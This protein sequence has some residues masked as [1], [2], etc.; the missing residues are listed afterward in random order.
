[1]SGHGG[2]PKGPLV[3]LVQAAVLAALVGLLFVTSRYFPAIHGRGATVA[4]I[5]FLLLAGTLTSQLVEPIKLPHLTGYLVAGAVAGPY[6]LNLVEHDAVED[7]AFINSLALA[8]IALAGGAELRLEVLRKSLRSL[9]WAMTV[10]CVLGVAAMTLV[11]FVARPLIPFARGMSAQMLLGVALLW[12]CISVSRSPSALLGILAQTRAQGP[13]ATFSVA[14]VM[15]SDV[16]VAVLF[17]AGMVIARPLIEPSATLSLQEFRELG[18]EILGSVAIGTTLGLALAAYMRLIG[19]QLILVLLAMGFGAW[20]VIRY[21][22]FDSLLTFLTAGFVVQNLSDQGEKFLH[23]I[24]RTGGVVY[25]LFFATAGAHLN[26]PLLAELWPAALLLGV[27]RAI[28]TVASARLAARF[29]GDPPMV[30]RWGWSSLISQAGLTLGLVV[31]VERTFPSFGTSFRALGIAVVALNEMVGP[32]F[33]KLGLDRA[34]ES[35]TEPA[36]TRAALTSKPPLGEL[37]RASLTPATGEAP[38][39]RGLGPSDG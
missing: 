7:M 23:A 14:F 4:S 35:S 8:L 11:F 31:L 3:R 19:T 38:A 27:G 28:V 12:G 6:V 21:L 18:H 24:E 30:R 22:S 17:A 39:E 13:V 15:L 34:G 29:A 25:V 10:Q 2:A 37:T 20:E 16:V 1:V 36:V 5:G 9:S 26:I 32:V 33:F